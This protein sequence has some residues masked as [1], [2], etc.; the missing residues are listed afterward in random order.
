[1]KITLKNNKQIADRKFKMQNGKYF[2]LLKNSIQDTITHIYQNP[3][4]TIQMIA[5][6]SG[7]SLEQMQKQIEVKA[8]QNGIDITK[9]VQELATAIENFTLIPLEKR[10]V[11]KQINKNIKQQNQNS[12][13]ILMT[14]VSGEQSTEQ[15]PTQVQNTG[16]SLGAN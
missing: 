4:D 11:M 7:K 9:L 10:L 8:D 3:N 12:R 5:I 15:Q 6:I 13:Q 1:M 2:D 16:M 14:L